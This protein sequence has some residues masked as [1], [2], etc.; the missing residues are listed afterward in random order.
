MIAATAIA[1]ACALAPSAGDE[2][3]ESLLKL[4]IEL[5]RLDQNAEALALFERAYAREP[6]PR[7]LAQIGLAHQ[8]LG[9]WIAA[10][11]A[12]ARAVGE[13][14]D[15]WIAKNRDPLETALARI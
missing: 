5:R 1:I 13:R 6:T 12:V 2:S 10:E 14:D 8:A 7:A 11:R 3:A 4:G 9:N 15:P